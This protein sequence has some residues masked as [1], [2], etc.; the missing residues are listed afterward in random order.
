MD[1]KVNV[2]SV[3]AHL[4]D[5]QDDIQTALNKTAEE[6]SLLYKGDDKIPLQIKDAIS[7]LQVQVDKTFDKIRYQIRKDYQLENFAVENLDEISNTIR[8][9]KEQIEELQKILKNR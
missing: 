8:N 7:T 9:L 2:C 4:F 5:F 6:I 1:T 3:S